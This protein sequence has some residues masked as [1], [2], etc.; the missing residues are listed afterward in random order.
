MFLNLGSKKR[1]LQGINGWEFTIW[2]RDFGL[3]SNTKLILGSNFNGRLGSKRVL[4]LTSWIQT[5]G[6]SIKR[7]YAD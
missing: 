2:F 3:N 7:I 6:A 4:F 5:F 1:S